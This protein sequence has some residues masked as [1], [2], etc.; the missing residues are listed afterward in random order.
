MIKRLKPPRTAEIRAA[1]KSVWRAACDCWAQSDSDECVPEL[2]L[3][4]A[5]ACKSQLFVGVLPRASGAEPEHEDDEHEYD[6]PFSAELWARMAADVLAA[7]PCPGFRQPSGLELQQVCVAELLLESEHVQQLL[8]KVKPKMKPRIELVASCTAQL[9]NRVGPRCLLLGAPLHE[10]GR[11]SSAAGFDETGEG[12][13]R[14]RGF[15]LHLRPYLAADTLALEEELRWWQPLQATSAATTG[16]LSMRD[17]IT[18]QMSSSSP[19]GLLLYEEEDH[20][21]DDEKR[22]EEPVAR[23]NTLLARLPGPFYQSVLELLLTRSVQEDRAGLSGR[24]FSAL[25]K[26]WATGSGL[27]GREHEERQRAMESLSAQLL[28]LVLEPLLLQTEEHDSQQLGYPAGVECLA[29]LT[30]AVW[31]LAYDSKELLVRVRALLRHASAQASSALDELEMDSVAFWLTVAAAC[32]EAV[33]V[34]EEE[35]HEAAEEEEQGGEPVA[36]LLTDAC[37]ELCSTLAGINDDSDSFST[38]RA[39]LFRAVLRVKSSRE[40]LLADSHAAEVVQ[41]AAD[42]LGSAVKA[43]SASAD[44]KSSKKK[45]SKKTSSLPTAKDLQALRANLA[46]L[47]ACVSTGPHGCELLQS[48]LAAQVCLCF[49]F[50]FFLECFGR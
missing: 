45:S 44:K 30:R 29:S 10:T 23:R 34:V 28:A 7:V 5:H 32:V 27:S 38:A 26:A 13:E 49:L 37:G 24:V 50:D 31:A 12:D 9:L 16:I 2:I 18:E 4:L 17:I 19:D 1:A 42:A 48:P 20:V 43:L 39:H 36:A 3:G 47:D 21:A 14:R 33:A 6:A 15:A 40:I 11:H 41:G 22:P 8:S 25:V 35:G 46:L